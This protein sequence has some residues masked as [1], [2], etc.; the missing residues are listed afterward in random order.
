MFKIHYITCPLALASLFVFGACSTDSSS[1][2][3]DR[4][5]VVP[6]TATTAPSYRGD[7]SIPTR[8]YV[9][10]MSDGKRDW[11][12]EFPEVATGYELRI[13]LGDKKKDEDVVVEGDKLTAADKQLLDALRKRNVNYEREG[14]YKNGK[15]Q[16]DPKGKNQV[17]GD[18]PGAELDPKGKE[19]KKSGGVDPWAGTEDKPA[20]TRRS[21]FL[22]LEK[23]K[24]LY[25][26]KKYELAV[27]FLKKLE[28]DYP[29]DV[30]IM[31][32]M[33]TLW[34]KV[35]QKELARQY[36]EKVLAVDPQNKPV[37]A[38]LK[39]L[40]V[41]SPQQTTPPATKKAPKKTAPAK[42]P[43]APKPKP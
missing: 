11:E 34:L 36:W 29:N 23:V 35:G 7:G 8:R 2:S 37:I 13:P 1:N 43:P 42:K 15:N 40:N 5:I 16:A 39:Q 22:G 25:R 31:S 9:V 20:P 21:Y 28:K 27:V 26:A 41:S 18:E 12:V 6:S 14:I 38:A 33:G 10:R 30:Q 4:V 17:G 24:R 32:M 3:S 19:A